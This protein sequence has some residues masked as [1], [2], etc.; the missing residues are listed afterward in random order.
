MAWRINC[1]LGEHR[2]YDKEESDWAL[3]GGA[4][5]RGR[6]TV[7]RQTPTASHC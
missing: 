3:G 6:C 2:L 4:S 7:A 1:A 5:T